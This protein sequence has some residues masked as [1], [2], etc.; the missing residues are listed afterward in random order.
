MS[1]I[2]REKLVLGVLGDKV[3]LRVGPRD[4]A[5]DIRAVMVNREINTSPSVALASCSHG[6]G[7][8]GVSAI[9]NGSPNFSSL[10]SPIYRNARQ[11]TYFGTNGAVRPLSI[12][13]NSTG[14]AHTGMNPNTAAKTVA[15]AVLM[16]AFR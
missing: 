15:L 7:A 2:I 13:P 3:K 5:H 6:A 12:V 14:F 10:L 4:E 1:T 16:L 8:T 9:A 11:A